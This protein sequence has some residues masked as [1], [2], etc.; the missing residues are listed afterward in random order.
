MAGSP[1]EDPYAPGF[2][3]RP[4]VLVARERVLDD[5]VRS[6]RRGTGSLVLVAPRGL[7]KTVLLA[8]AAER[9]GLNYGWPRVRLEM[10]SSGDPQRQFVAEAGRVYNEL[11]ETTIGDRPRLSQLTLG[12]SLAGFG[13]TAS[14]TWSEQDTARE[15]ATNALRRLVAKAALGGTGVIV[16]LDELQVVSKARLEPLSAAFQL[17]AEERWPVVAIAAGLPS[18]RRKGQLPTYFERASWHEL[19]MLTPDETLEALVLPAQRVGRSFEARAARMVAYESGGYPFAVQVLGSSTWRAAGER[20]EIDVEA[21]EAGLDNGLAELDRGIHSSRWEQA[22]PKEQSY[23]LALATLG[24]G[25][26]IVTSAMVAEHLGSTPR[27]LSW[28]RDALIQQ[29]TL[30]PAPR[31]ALRFAVPS[32][33][34]Y[35]LRQHE[36]TDQKVRWDPTWSRQSL[37]QS[38][39][40][41][42]GQ[43]SGDVPP[44]PGS[45][46]SRGHE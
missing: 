27:Q 35:V 22:T 31:S 43:A 28:V 3:S 20:G 40:E 14:L 8:E 34:A 13:A 36:T 32:F 42:P 16:T 24:A 21:A 15:T 23:L 37:R 18:L 6:T 9:V 1:P 33:A 44:H 11:A 7:G 19:S 26:G 46:R 4:P 29:G 45:G 38:P 10:T 25:Q 41:T 39:G 12:G 2:G 30:D 5:V 17:A